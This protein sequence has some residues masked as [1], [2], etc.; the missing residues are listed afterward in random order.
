MELVRNLVEQGHGLRKNSN[1]KLRQPLNLFAYTLAS[2]QTPLTKDFEEILADELNVKS[3]KF[4][5][6]LEFDLQIT[7]ELK[8]EGLARELER[9]VQDM[10]KKSGLQVGEQANLTYDTDDDEIKAAF[11]LF[12]TK[13]TYI[14]GIKQE[15]G[16]KAEEVEI[17]GKKI[18]IKLSN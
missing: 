7:P 17:E 3:V 1:I 14:K 2:T 15:K 16:V 12:D 10:R 8:Q 11:G 18:L 6:K 4:G 5:E 9:A 13:K